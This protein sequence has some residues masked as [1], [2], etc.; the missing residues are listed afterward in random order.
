M[1]VYALYG[2]RKSVLAFMILLS[3]TS[4]GVAIAQLDNVLCMIQPHLQQY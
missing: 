3:L 2:C 1:R 4:L